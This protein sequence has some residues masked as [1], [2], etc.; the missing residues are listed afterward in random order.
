MK[1]IL[2]ICLILQAVMAQAQTGTGKQLRAFPITDY[3][4]DLNDSVKLVQVELPDDLQFRDKQVGLIRGTYVDKHTDTVQKG[5]GKCHLIKGNYYYFTVTQMNSGEALKKGDL[6]YTLVEPGEQY[7]GLV[8]ALAAH[9]IRLLNVYDEPFYDRFEVFRYWS[10][11]SEKILLD[12]MV[13]DIRF[14]GQYFLENNPSLNKSIES[15]AFAGKK[16]LELMRDC[17]TEWLTDFLSYIRAR[18]RL[19]AG[20]DWKSSEIFA[21]WLSAGAPVPVRE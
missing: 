7:N 14:T 20:R 13:A 15:G 5:Y 8:P 18:P 16:L 12:S 3:I 11:P 10:Q 1:Q 6:L 17:K 9:Y 19:Y 4:I 21:T 2:W